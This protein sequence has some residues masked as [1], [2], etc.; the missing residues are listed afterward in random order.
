MISAGKRMPQYPMPRRSPSPK[1]APP[2]FAS[3][4]KSAPRTK[5]RAR[6][7]VRIYKAKKDKAAPVP[8]RGTGECFHFLNNPLF[9]KLSE[10]QFINS[11]YFVL[12]EFS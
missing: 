1:N 5:P 11:D 7:F 12:M 8:A 6:S 3:W 2:C 10:K 9:I 4:N